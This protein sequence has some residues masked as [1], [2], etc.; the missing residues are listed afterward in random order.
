LSTKHG[1]KSGA[2]IKISSSLLG[3]RIFEQL[4]A[5]K[6]HG[7]IRAAHMHAE[8]GTFRIFTEANLPDMR[9][10]MHVTGSYLAPAALS[11]KPT[12][13]LIT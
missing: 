12:P 1:Y 7:Y 5:G 9:L 11:Y 2:Q 4:I 8:V 6:P 10:D 3:A 13:Q